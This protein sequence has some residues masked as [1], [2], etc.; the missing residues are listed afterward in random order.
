MT[1]S[2][3]GY[4]QQAVSPPESIQCTENPQMLKIA[5]A[6]ADAPAAKIL[7]GCLKALSTL[8]FVYLIFFRFS[9]SNAF[10]RG[11]KDCHNKERRENGKI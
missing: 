4:F 1:G 7:P 5:A 11:A 9:S 6:Y 10:W 3:Y 8:Q 2:Q